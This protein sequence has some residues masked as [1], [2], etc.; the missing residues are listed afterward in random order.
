MIDWILNFKFNTLLA[1]FLY[2][3]PLVFCLYGYTVRTW[4]NY[5]KDKADREV[6]KYYSPTDTIGSLLGRVFITLLPIGNI[7]AALFD[8]STEVFGRFFKH[9]ERV[10]SQPLVPKKKPVDTK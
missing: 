1:I 10:F 5:Q 7:C 3:I 4:V 9:L 8:L 2:W 6:E